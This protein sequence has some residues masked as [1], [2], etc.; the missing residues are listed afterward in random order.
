MTMLRSELEYER[1]KGRKKRRVAKY[2]TRD[3]ERRGKETDIQSLTEPIQSNKAHT[4]PNQIQ[5]SQ[6]KPN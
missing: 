6:T 5:S 3:I 2:E 1:K 4:K